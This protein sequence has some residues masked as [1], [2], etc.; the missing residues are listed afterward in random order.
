MSKTQSE[1]MKSVE[2]MQ[3]KDSTQTKSPV[4]QAEKVTQSKQVKFNFTSDLQ[5]TPSASTLESAHVEPQIDLKNSKQNS[6]IWTVGSSVVKDLDGRKIYLNRITRITTLRDKKIQGAVECIKSK[7]INSEIRVLQIGSNDLESAEVDDVMEE[8]EN[9]V[10]II[11]KEYSNQQ[12]VIGEILPRYYHERLKTAEF[13]QKRCQFNLLLKDLC[14]YRNLEF[15]QYDHAR[16]TDFYDGIH[17]NQEG[18][19][20]F[21][22]NLKEVI[23]PLVDVRSPTENHRQYNKNQSYNGKGCQQ[24]YQNRLIR[25]PRNWNPGVDYRYNRYNQTNQYFGRSDYNGSVK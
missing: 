12:L 23:N 1:V 13:E 5:N 19:K 16:T 7:K 25:N 20:N 18:I 3:M 17:L 10:E 24:F 4:T 14:E 6:K 9:M 21:V 11:K 22:K 2:N 15:V 8:Y